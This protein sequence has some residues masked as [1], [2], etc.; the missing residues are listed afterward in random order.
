MAIESGAL[1]ELDLY[2]FAEGTH[3]R[4]F[5]KLGAHLV[6]GATHFAVWA[7][8]AESVAVIGDWNGWN[9]QADLFCAAAAMRRASGKAAARRRASRPRLQVPR[10][11]R[12]TAA[13]APT[14]PTRSPST[15]EVAPA[16]ASRVWDLEHDW[17]R[18]RVDGIAR[19]RNALTRRRCR[20]TSCTSARG[21]ATT[22]A[23][24]AT[25]SSREQL[26]D[27]VK[28]IGFTHVE[29][30][31]LTRAP[32]LRLVGLPDDR[33]LRA[34]LALRHAAGPDVP[35]RPP[36][37]PRH[38]RDPRLGALALPDRRARPAVLRRHAPLRARRPA[39][40][41]PPGV[42][43]E[44]LQ[45]RPQRGAQLPDLV[46]ATSGSTS[47]TS[48]ACASTA[49]PRCST[50]TTRASPA[51]GSP[52]ATAA[53]K[54]SRRSSSC[55]RSTSRSDRAHPRRRDDRRGVDRLARRVAADRGRRPRLRHEMEHGLDARHAG[56]PAARAGASR[57][58][59]TTRSPSR[60]STPSTR[61]SCCRSRTTRS[62]TAR[63]R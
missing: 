19:P 39:P 13:T 63:A 42:E 57:A 44:H 62:C 40:G 53:R 50:S 4:L 59:T 35:R 26:A 16:T 29:L 8:N 36:A 37:R 28:E 31:P 38:R 5:D 6:D 20:S 3:T 12:A 21:G 60:W 18:R 52:T 23:A 27:Y 9:D 55:A 30:M 25:A 46:G 51:S 58:T 49:S 33:L 61:T 2:L 24:R 11:P 54:T 7:P 43:L 14:R 41:L 22:A 17:Q 32:V 47:T 10:S 56:L 45:L 1:S 15:R 48:T 34:D